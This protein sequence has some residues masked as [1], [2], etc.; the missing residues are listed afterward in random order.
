MGFEKKT[1]KNKVLQSKKKGFF[2]TDYVFVQGAV[3]Q[4][5]CY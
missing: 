4:N 3:M 2:L 5:F 1:W